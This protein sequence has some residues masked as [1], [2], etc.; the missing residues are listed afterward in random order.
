[1][2]LVEEREFKMNHC[3]FIIENKYWFFCWRLSERVFLVSL[4]NNKTVWSFNIKLKPLLDEVNER[5]AKIML[6]IKGVR[7]MSKT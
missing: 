6:K 2:N 7:N 1:M 3:S 4:K 5:G